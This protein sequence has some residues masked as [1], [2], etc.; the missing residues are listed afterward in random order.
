MIKSIMLTSALLTS[1]VIVGCSKNDSTPMSPPKGST[2]KKVVQI[3]NNFFSPKDITIAK[4]DT[5]VWF[6]AGISG[7]TTTSGTSCTPSGL[8]NSG[9]LASGHSYQVIFD[10]THVSQTGNIPYYCTL[11]CSMGMVGSVTVNP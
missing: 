8:W 4:G 9:A 5:V 1:L 11:H 2:T 7:H 10:D 6:D 3:K